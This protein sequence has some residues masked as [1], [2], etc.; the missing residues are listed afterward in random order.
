[1]N[2]SILY[3][4]AFIALPWVP[5]ACLQYLEILKYAVCAVHICN[6]CILI[7]SNSYKEALYDFESAIKLKRTLP[8]PHVCAGLVHMLH[9]NNTTRATRCFS[10]AIFVDPT[11]IRG[12]LCRAI[13]F[14]R[15]AKVHVKYYH[16]H[17]C[18][19]ASKC[20]HVCKKM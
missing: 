2:A 6:T 1:M 14:Q 5:S 7:F 18:Y 17:C 10:T 20:V 4:L 9:N 11:C 8:S 3:I 16:L 13:A 15:D 12:Y 19:L